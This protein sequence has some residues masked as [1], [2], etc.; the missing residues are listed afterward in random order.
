MG[1]CECGRGTWID[2]EEYSYPSGS[3]RRSRRRF[4]AVWESTGELVSGTAGIP[5][6]YFSVP[7]KIVSKGRYI[8]GWLY[9]T[10]ESG[11]DTD[12]GTAFVI[13][14][15]AKRYGGDLDGFPERGNR[16]RVSA[17]SGIWSGRRGFVVGPGRIH[18]DGRGIPTNTSPGEH[19]PV[20]W[21]E[22]VAVEL[23]TGQLI[24]MFKNRLEKERG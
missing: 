19:K 8:A 7:A 23:D 20:N 24:I 12:T 1:R 3:L 2:P 22:E 5:D 13:F 21:K 6:S 10:T 17:G 18:T 14:R 16:V 4:R 15:S 11:L 9:M